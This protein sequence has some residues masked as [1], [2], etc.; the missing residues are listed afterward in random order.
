MNAWAAVSI[1]DLGRVVTGATPKSSEPD[2]WGE[3]LDFITPSDQEAGRRTVR[4][5]RRLS[6]I[7]AE[8]FE[9]RIVPAN[10]TCFTCIG[11]TIG[12]VTLTADRAVTN[13]QINSV[14]PNVLHDGRF[15]YYL[16][17]YR[18]RDITQIASGS[19]TPI[20]NKTHFS[21]FTVHVPDLSMQQAI[22]EAL[23]V[24]DDKIAINERI[25]DTAENLGSFLFEYYFPEAI[26]HVVGCT[27]LPEGWGVSDLGSTTETIETGSRPKGGV[28]RYTSGVPSI[29]AESVVRLAKFDFSKV[30]YVPEEFFVG[31]R[32]GVIE[33]RDILVY[34]DGGKPGDFKPH[35][36]M[37]GNGFPFDRMSI[38]EHVYRVRMKSELGQE[39]GYYWL[40]SP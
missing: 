9:R 16:L 15:I 30:K 13:Q 4:P 12:K 6:Q 27:N 19:A 31:L 25:L 34:K 26:R 29:G 1:G 24:L 38:N 11:S 20:I 21:N 32:R 36:S 2:S 14:V 8:R 39:F 17:L 35:V 7:G 22:A 18:S 23:G 33:D 37:F 28:A 40:S 3:F 5:A 10:S